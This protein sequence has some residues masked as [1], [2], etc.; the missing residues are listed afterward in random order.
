MAKVCKINNIP[1]PRIYP[2]PTKI[3]LNNFPIFV[4]PTMGGGGIDTTLI[5]TSQELKTYL[6][7]EKDYVSGVIDNLLK[8]GEI[9]KIGE[10]RFKIIG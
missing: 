3:S 4:K 1:L 5:K 7:K 9:F 8:E 10:G 6:G 2:D